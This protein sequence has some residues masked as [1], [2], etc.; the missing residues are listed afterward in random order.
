LA[1][2]IGYVVDFA[3]AVVVDAVA[4]LGFGCGC[5][6]GGHFAIFADA[7]T[8]PAL[9]LAGLDE[10]FIGQSIA[11]IVFAVAGFGWSGCGDAIA[12][13]AS[14]A[15]LDA[16]TAVGGAL[17]GESFID[18][19]VAVIVFVV[20]FFWFGSGSSAT[21][22]ATV[23]T[24]LGAFSAG[25]LASADEI[26]V[27]TPIAVIIA[28]VTEFGAGFDAGCTDRRPGAAFAELG[29]LLAL[30]NVLT[31]RALCGFLTGAAFVDDTVAVVV[32]TV[33][34]FCVFGEGLTCACPPAVLAVL[35]LFTGACADAADALCIGAG[36]AGVAGFFFADF[37]FGADA[38]F[39][40]FVDFAVA[41]VVFAVTHFFA[42][43]D[44]IYALS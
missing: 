38:V 34:L 22:P 9:G 19:T 33:A 35:G 20:A 4:Q 16:F 27:D 30:A 28:S 13:F 23:L 44:L 29:P 10:S 2:S 11:V 40:I 14:I 18:A 32:E 21:C 12:P 37:G 6:A 5:R 24:G 42:R 7:D 17:F 15:E 39:E 8:S 25:G 36:G 26:V 43:D 41:V 31:T 3:I 1:V